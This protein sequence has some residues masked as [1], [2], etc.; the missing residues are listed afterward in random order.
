MVCVA[1]S[2]SRP[3]PTAQSPPIPSFFSLPAGSFNSETHNT[4]TQNTTIYNTTVYNDP[5]ALPV[6]QQPAPVNIVGPVVTTVVG[7]GNSVASGNGNTVGRA[8]PAGSVLSARVGDYHMVSPDGLPIA[9][10][11]LHLPLLMPEGARCAMLRPS[12]PTCSSCGFKSGFT[13]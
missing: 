1:C 4:I 3:T 11:C 8:G 12:S 9:R 2:C 10:V 7:T 6:Q 13:V 5:D